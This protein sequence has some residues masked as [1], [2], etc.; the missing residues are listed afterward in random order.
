MMFSRTRACEDVDVDACIIIIPTLRRLID[1]D[2]SNLGTNA[3]FESF[4]RLQ[5][6]HVMMLILMPMLM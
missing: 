1:D 5:R 3:F 4:I 2:E 6:A